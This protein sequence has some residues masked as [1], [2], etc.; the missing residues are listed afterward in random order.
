MVSKTKEAK[1]EP[2]LKEIDM[3][4]SSFLHSA[5]E[6]VRDTFVSSI[7]ELILSE[8]TF[9][10]VKFSYGALE[11]KHVLELA[12]SLA[13]CKNMKHLYLDSNDFGNNGILALIEVLRK[14]KDSLITLSF[15]NLPVW[16]T[17]STEVLQ[18]FVEAIEESTALIRLGFD[19]KEFRHQEYMDRVSKHLKKNFD[20]VRETRLIEKLKPTFSDSLT[21][22][23]EYIE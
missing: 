22:S 15:Q 6:Y 1:E 18:K 21:S 13:T 3:N 12:S 5:G 7:S 17:P 11:Q 20:K 9:E 8:P 10:V 19:L 2:R 4:A 23:E 16:Q 14:N